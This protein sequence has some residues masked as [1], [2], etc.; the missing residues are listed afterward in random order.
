MARPTSDKT[1]RAEMKT[2]E[3]GTP[4]KLRSLHSSVYNLS[5][6]DRKLTQQA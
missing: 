5:I 2:R 3:I 1:K 6:Y 4:A